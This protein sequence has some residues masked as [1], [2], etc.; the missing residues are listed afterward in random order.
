MTKQK[1]LDKIE[2]LKK[3]VNE[4]E[5]KTSKK[6]QILSKTGSVL[7]ESDKLTLKEAVEEADLREANLYGADLREAELQNAKFYGK[8][9]TTKIKKEQINDFLT[10]LG[11]I[12]E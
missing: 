11:V 5:T 6:L 1:A 2:E 7:Y 3:Y 10:A 4:E 8:G 9:G 12:A